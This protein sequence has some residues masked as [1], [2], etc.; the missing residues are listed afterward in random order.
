VFGKI[1]GGWEIVKQIEAAQTDQRDRPRTPIQMV[2][3]T[4]SE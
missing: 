1:T 4:V 2:R 3:V